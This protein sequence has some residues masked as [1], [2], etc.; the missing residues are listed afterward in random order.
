MRR[1]RV[2]GP[3]ARR[4]VASVPAGAHALLAGR[5]STSSSSPSPASAHVAD[6]GR[7]GAAGV[8][9]L[10]EKPPAPDAAGAAALAALDPPWVGFNRRFDPG[11][12]RAHAVPTTDRSTS[13]LEIRYRRQSWGAHAVHDDALPDLGPHLVDWARWLTGS[14]VHEVIDARDAPRAGVVTLAPRA[15]RRPHRG[16]G[17]PPAP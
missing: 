6:A 8:A 2:A 14:E 1:D 9:V 11:A 10:V 3:P 4:P 7:A 12:P 5:P 16:R 17:R 13:H 15:G